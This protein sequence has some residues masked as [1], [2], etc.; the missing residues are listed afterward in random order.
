MTPDDGRQIAILA[1]EAPHSPVK[2]AAIQ[3]AG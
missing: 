2:A 3:A 1:S